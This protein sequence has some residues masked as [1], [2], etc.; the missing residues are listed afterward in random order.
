MELI[1]R[2][3]FK[4]LA[5]LAMG[6]TKAEHVSVSLGDSTGGTARFANNQITQNIDVR[7]QS[8][9]V[10]IA[11]GKKHGSASTT[12]LTDE[13]I[14][15]TVKRAEQIAAVSPEDEEFL[16]P[17]PAQRMPIFPT[18]RPE[19][20]AATPQQRT[21]AA[22]D[23][24]K[25][26]L[27]ENL[28]AAGTVSAYTSAVGLAANSGLFGFETRSSAEFSLTATGADSSG[29]VSNNN[30]SFN[31]LG[32]IERTKIAIEKAKRSANPRELPAGKYTV[33]LEPAAVSGLF[34]P[35]LGA[36]NAKSYYRGTSA[37][38]DKLGRQV[39]DSRLS[40]QNRPDHPSLLGDGFSGAGLPADYKTWIRDGILKELN[41]D[42]FT[43]KKYNVAPS[44]PLDAAHLSGAGAAGETLDSLLSGTQRAV[45]ITNFW[46]IRPVNPTDLTLTGMTRDGTFL[47]EDGKIVAGLQNF[48]W[49]DSPLRAFNA[50]DAFTAP[51]DAWTLERNKMFLP[52]FKIRD[53][54]FSSVTKF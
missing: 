31:D 46:Y 28:V 44:A 23:S 2:D 15:D 17:L 10:S 3:G 51:D 12:T 32:V 19:T 14:R 42:R 35:L 45:L 39:L 30:R 26:C 13:A 37:L 27:A 6:A 8:F 53:F 11:N 1:D 7:R 36:L 29:W 22:G 40:L 38:S 18:L 43:A 16:P 49:H 5:D 52:A 21:A 20:L 24:I 34:G 41:Y 25:L 9:T 54:N 33:I 50:V 47:V 4:K 48:R